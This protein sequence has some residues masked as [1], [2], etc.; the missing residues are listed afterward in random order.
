MRCAPLLAC[1]CIAGS[2]GAQITIDDLRDQLRGN[3][4]TI[5]F[6]KSLASL[7]QLSGDIELSG[8]RYEIDDEQGTTIS[9]LT[10]P[11][12][13]SFDVFGNAPVSLRAEG[14]LAVAR[15][16]Q[17]TADLFGGA[18]PGLEASIDSDWT[19]LSGLIGAGPEFEVAQGLRVAAISSLSLAYVRNDARYAGPGAPLAE[20][21]VD[22]IGLN[23]ESWVGSVGIAGRAQWDRPLPRGLRTS[24]SARYDVRWVETLR[25]DDPAQDFSTTLQYATVRGDLFG[26][27]GLS[28]AGGDVEWQ[29][30]AGIKRFTQGDLFGVDQFLQLGGGVRLIDALPIGAIVS[31]KGIAIIGRDLTG[32]SVGV[33]LGF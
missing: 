7:I 23:W 11:G 12:G 24:L 26:P 31:L 25:S 30:F 28:F 20:A 10:L 27:T 21:I 15:L 8:A 3:L 33:S 29:T 6:A 18:L 13:R 22:G 14:A 17:Q 4:S 32:F 1:V 16:N 19:T 2:A 5:E 9:L